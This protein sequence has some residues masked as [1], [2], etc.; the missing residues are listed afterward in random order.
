[1]SYITFDPFRIWKP[2]LNTQ[3]KSLVLILVNFRSDFIPTSTMNDQSVFQQN[4]MISPTPL[5]NK[6]ISYTPKHYV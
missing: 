3:F 1:M 4:P 2:S 5:L 6:V